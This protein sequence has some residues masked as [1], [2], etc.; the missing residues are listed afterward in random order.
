[1]KYETFIDGSRVDSA[2]QLLGFYDPLDQGQQFGDLI[3]EGIRYYDRRILFHVEHRDRLL[4]S[5]KALDINA[6]TPEEY[7]RQ[8][9]SAVRSAEEPSGYV[10][11]LIT[12]GNA[13]WGI[14]PSP[15]A[16]GRTIIVLGKIDLAHH[17]SGSDGLS[18]IVAKHRRVPGR[19][20]DARH[21]WG[22]IYCNSKLAQR[23]AK[24]HRATDAL[25][26]T[27]EGIISEATVA[28]VFW[29]SQGKILTPTIDE[30]TNCLPGITRSKVKDIAKAIGIQVI[31][32]HYYRNELVLADELFLTGTGAGVVPIQRLDGRQL[33]TGRIGPITERIMQGYQ[34][35]ISE[36]SSLTDTH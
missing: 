17:H 18:L 24:E 11:L 28:N 30:T 5:A 7:D 36:P 19:C 10:R 6:P 20:I 23:E 22:G 29:V 3:F 4:R 8:L 35:L 13:G 31:E 14:D 16:R 2:T 15:T 34:R 25:M 33:R 21:K 9:F 12:R 27:L 26:L 32:G 1:M